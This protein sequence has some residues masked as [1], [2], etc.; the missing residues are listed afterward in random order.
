MPSH[1]ETSLQRD[2][3][4][5][6]TKVTEMAGLAEGA[7]RDCIKAVAEHDREL[8]YAIILRDQY[9]DDKEKEIDRLCLEFLVRQ[10]PVGGPLRFA[11]STIR[12]NLELERVGD[13]AES[14]ARRLLK[15]AEVPS[16]FPR[17]EFAEI[18]E[19]STAMLHDAVKAFV[20]QDAE[21]ARKTIEL[22]DGIDLRK[23]KLI[24]HLVN[25]FRENKMPFEALDPL[26]MMVRRFERVADQARNICTEVLY[27]C[28]GE[29]AKHPGSEAF[30]VLF[31]D[32]HDD[33]LTKI[34]EAIANSLG[35]SKFIF[36]SAGLDPQP[37][38]PQTIAFLREKGHDPSYLVPKS[39]HQVPNLEHYH[40]I[41]ALS[42]EVKKT[43]P[44]RPRKGVYLD[45][46]VAKPTG[47]GLPPE[48]VQA[49]FESAYKT[50]K[51]S[52]HDFIQAILKS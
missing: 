51:E 10:Q 27:M 20:E 2:I 5:I 31:V 41:I 38:E 34:A 28:T 40:L 9:I 52:V 18:A 48:Q 7:L 1:L 19:H 45:W 22:E 42:P 17:E 35:Q 29:Y 13:Y 11:Y 3:D 37:I 32:E 46:N 23:S 8:A 25:L 30:R 14:I 15:L 44:R 49:R 36:T 50:I 12:I 21:L 43:F 16:T 24:R 4:R 47:K 6:R 39:L 33:C 26:T